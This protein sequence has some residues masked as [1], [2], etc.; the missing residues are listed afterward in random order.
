MHLMREGLDRMTGIAAS[1][2]ELSNVSSECS[3]A[4][5]DGGTGHAHCP[6]A[7]VKL[8]AKLR[9]PRCGDQC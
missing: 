7:W 6:Y 8:T 5:D 1:T 3:S 4:S 2:E 9:L